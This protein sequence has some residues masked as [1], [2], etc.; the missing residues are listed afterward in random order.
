MS[1][2]AWLP[3]A[4]VVTL[5]L[6]A[7]DALAG[8]Q[9][10]GHACASIVE[11]AAR[12]ACYDQAFGHPSGERATAAIP[13][14]ETGAVDP[15]VKARQEFGLSEADKRAREPSRAP[16]SVDRI[17]G[18][19]EGVSRRPTG[20]LVVRLDSGQVWVET[21]TY[22]GAVVKAGDEVTIRKSALGSYMLV[23]PGHVA[24][25]VRRLK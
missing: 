6:P 11:D 14:A 2:L 15:Q 17:S 18:T 13:A 22:T 16:A 12:L 21:Q 23:T 5:S 7:R 24:T 19:V 20:E 25:Y 10:A 1:R 4:A 8:P 9:S 3:L